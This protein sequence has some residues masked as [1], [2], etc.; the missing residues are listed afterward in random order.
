MSKPQPS[1][2]TCRVR[3]S[4]ASFDH[5]YDTV[6]IVDTTP[7]TTF[8]TQKTSAH[9]NAHSV[10]HQKW[11]CGWAPKFKRDQQPSLACKYLPQRRNTAPAP[12]SKTAELFA[13]LSKSRRTKPVPAASLTEPD[14]NRLGFSK[15][16]QDRTSTGSKYYRT[17]P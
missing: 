15:I 7:R 12:T 10:N 9:G 14:L 1:S 3:F 13:L 4:R 2:I 16:S 8:G 5:I 17:Q 11:L 6:V